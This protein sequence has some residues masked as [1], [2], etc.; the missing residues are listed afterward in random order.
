M[1]ITVVVVSSSYST[2]LLFTTLVF[3]APNTTP[4][5]KIKLMRL[6]AKTHTREELLEN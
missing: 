5:K 1:M 3:T 4:L 2:Q 6:S